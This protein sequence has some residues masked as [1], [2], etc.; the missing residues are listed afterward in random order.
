MESSARDPWIRLFNKYSH[1]YSSAENDRKFKSFAGVPPEVAETTFE[2]YFDLKNMPIRDY[3][4]IVLHYLKNVPTE[5]RG[6]QI[7]KISK[8]T[9]QKRLW[10]TLF[11]LD[12]V[13]DEIHIDERFIPF[14]PTK[15][16]FANATLVVD[17]TDCAIDRPT[18]REDRNL[19][20]NGRNKENTHGRYNLKYTVAVQI[21]MGKICFVS[22]SEPSSK[23]D[24]TAFRECGLVEEMEVEEIV[25]ADKGYQGHPVCLSPYKGADIGPIEEAFNEVLASVRQIVECVFSRLKIFS[26]LEERF[27]CELWKH[28][29]VFNVCAQITNISLDDSPLWKNINHFL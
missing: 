18:H 27:S 2:K 24:I 14:F 1:N 5:E 4:F 11:Y 20:S 26:V 6:C 7:F 19:Y 25:L 12:L 17:A 3:L 9:Y 10:D 15:G 16:P 29:S 28:D 22:K 23:S 13:M 8:P 21:V